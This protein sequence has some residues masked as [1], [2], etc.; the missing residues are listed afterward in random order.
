MISP[1]ASYYGTTFDE[2][3]TSTDSYGLV[4]ENDSG[5]TFCGVQRGN[6]MDFTRN[7]QRIDTGAEFF[8]VETDFG[9]N[10]VRKAIL[11][12]DGNLT[13]TNVTNPGSSLSVLETVLNAEADGWTAEWQANTLKVTIQSTDL[14]FPK[15]RILRQGTDPGLFQSRC[16]YYTGGIPPDNDGFVDRTVS[17]SNIN[18]LMSNDDYIYVNYTWDEII[19][20]G[21]DN[22]ELTIFKGSIPGH[23]RYYNLCIDGEVTVTGDIHN[24]GFISIKAGSDLHFAENAGMLVSG[25]LNIEG[26]PEESPVILDGPYRLWDGISSTSGGV[27]NVEGAI[28]HNPVIGFSLRGSSIISHSRIEGAQTGIE[29]QSVCVDYVITEN[30]F[31]DCLY[32]IKVTNNYSAQQ[33]SMIKLNTFLNNGWGVLCYNSNPVLFSN[34]ISHSTRNGILMMRESQPVLKSNMIANTVYESDARPEIQMETNSYPVLNGLFNDINTDGNGCALYHNTPTS[35]KLSP[36]KATNNYWGYTDLAAII[37]SIHPVNWK[38]LVEPFSRYMNTPYY[39]IEES[40]HQALIAE[41]TGDLVT[42]KSLYTGVVASCPDSLIALQSLGRLNAIYTVSDSLVTDIRSIYTQYYAACSDSLLLSGAVLKEIMLDRIDQSYDNALYS[43]DGLLSESSTEL[44]S[45]LCLL[46]IAYTIEDMLYEDQGK[47]G[48]ISQEYHQNGLHIRSL[49]DAQ[50]T[51]SDLLNRLLEVSDQNT[52][53]E[54]ITPTNI[55]LSNYPNPFN[56]STTISYALPRSGKVKLAIYNLKGQRIKDLV[57]EFQLMGKYK[58][59]WNGKDRHNNSVASGIYFIRL[60]AGK[61]TKVSK[62]LML[63]GSVSKVGVNWVTPDEE[64]G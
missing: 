29:L 52:A 61:N 21:L 49:K 7:Y 6:G 59:V 41:E 50:N 56:P 53:Y 33:G 45:I 63:N 31:S 62:I 13:L 3:V 43:Y 18:T 26:V 40:F 55:K 30:S 34:S 5:K 4:R 64:K 25:T 57:D 24:D 19:A 12:G 54:V 58:T 51:I 23:T 28:I 44:D 27:L 32:G 10:S 11:S 46:D 9:A 22:G 1:S 60:D 42:A 47:S 37:N 2:E 39:F 38:V 48:S 36:L 15:Y 8:V 14:V 35:V 16:V 17:V 20:M